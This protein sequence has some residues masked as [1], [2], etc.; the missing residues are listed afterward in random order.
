M[1]SAFDGLRTILGNS[2]VAVPQV[3]TPAVEDPVVS[4]PPADPPPPAN[5]PPLAVVSAEPPGGE[6][7]DFPDLADLDRG[8]YTGDAGSA[9]S[10]SD[11]AAALDALDRGLSDVAQKPGSPNAPLVNDASSLELD[12][13]LFTGARVRAQQPARASGAIASIAV[14]RE[15]SGWA[16]AAVMAFGLVLGATAAIAVFHDEVSHIVASW[17][18]G[19]SSV[20]RAK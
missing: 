3:D 19:S 8:L 5:E 12:E 7:A 17:D 18:T 10:D 11:T 20:H 16:A 15:I 6:L 9:R 13:G 4:T 2:L 1:S 14:E